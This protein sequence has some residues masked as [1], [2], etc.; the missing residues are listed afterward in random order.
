MSQSANSPSRVLI[1]EDEVHARRY[2]RELLTAETGVVV[3]GEA[4]DGVQASEMITALA[5]DLVFLDIQIPELDAFEVI[6]RVGNQRMPAFIFVTAF[7]EYAIR[8]FEVDAL[9]YLRK[10]FDQNRLHTA[11]QRFDRYRA[12]SNEPI[13]DVSRSV[14]KSWRRRIAIKHEDCIRFIPVEQIL[15]V[16]A[17]NKYVVIR[18]A[19]HSYISR[20]TI[21]SMIA[22]LSP[23]QFVRISRSLVVRK[24]AISEVKPLFH[25]DHLVVLADG[26]E[27]ALSRTYRESFFSEMG[28]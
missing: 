1:V 8:A 11:L 24:S 3:A 27:L 28:R 23:E 6:T 13:D 20:Q 9:D 5:P 16:E 10:P 4:A 7:S 12:R 14:A 17:A 22:E 25:G 21:Q 18:T 15:W 2:L 19:D 26:T